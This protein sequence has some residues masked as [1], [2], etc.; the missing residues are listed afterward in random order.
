MYF[1]ASA[2]VGAWRTTSLIVYP[3]RVRPLPTAGMR[4]NGAGC[5]DSRPAPSRG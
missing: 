4:G 3:R 2:A 5:P 1:L